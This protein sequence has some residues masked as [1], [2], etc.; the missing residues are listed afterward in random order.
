MRKF[1]GLLAVCFLFSAPVFAQHGSKPE[2]GGGHIPAHGPTAFKA[3]AHPAPPVKDQPDRPGHPNA[4]HV[5]IK[6][7]RWS[8][9]IPDAMTSTTIWIIRGHTGG[10]PGVSVAATFGILLEEAQ[11]VS[12]SAGSILTSPRTISASAQ[13]GSG[14]PTRL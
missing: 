2:V 6:G 11:A 4:P 9:T 12:G 5:D 7:D 8:A 1:V 13:T 3:P 14:I 10:L